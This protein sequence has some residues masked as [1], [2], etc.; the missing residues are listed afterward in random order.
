MKFII[1]ILIFSFSSFA[2]DECPQNDFPELNELEELKAAIDWHAASDDEVRKAHCTAKNAPTA[3]EMT[4]W[5]TDKQSSPN[6]DRKVNGI[7]FE[8]ESIE[9]IEAFRHLTTFVDI[10]GYKDPAKHKDFS[11]TCK[12]VDCALSEIFG[13]Q[14]GQ[15]LLYMQRRYGMNG[16]HIVRD[17]ASAWKKEELDD[18]ILSLSDFPEG[19]M[20]V[21]E[22][23]TL[24][25][26]PRGKS[27]G[28]T[29]ANAVITIFDL[30][31]TQSKEQRRAT[32]T[33]EVGHVIAGITDSDE[34]DDW[35]KL[36]G[37]S[38][39][40]FVQDGKTLS[41]P[42]ASNEAAIVSEYGTTNERED[43]AEAV[44]AY[45]YSPGKLK[46]K[47]PEKYNMLKSVVFDNVEYSSEQA[48]SSPKRTSDALKLKVADKIKNWVPTADELK[49]I[50]NRCSQRAV[51]DLIAQGYADLGDNYFKSCYE[52]SVKKQTVEF[53]K[54]E[55][56]GMPNEKF[57]E[58]MIRNAVSD[59]APDKLLKITTDAQASHRKAFRD[60]LTKKDTLACDPGF[61][62]YGSQNFKKEELGFES[63]YYRE[64]LNKV[65]TDI[66]TSKANKSF[67]PNQIIR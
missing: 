24:I 49:A 1:I 59:I 47:S 54:T 60:V 12:K 36:S 64:S 29:L 32:V 13:S 23:R 20:P 30:W 41:V 39:K 58:P 63:Y 33:H 53:L 37:W 56:K 19:V 57:L 65:W 7:S 18:V 44:V 4:K 11:S 8:D 6:I 51:E 48:C 31:H 25:H 10:V 62:Q 17:N 50:G 66:C 46:E 55:M 35:K 26:A 40:E 52:T 38:T 9:N 16:S 61:L 45:R 21:Q 14:T 42:T 28:N 34:H 27:S 43:F 22:S 67:Q 5:L 15:Q 3:A 2:H